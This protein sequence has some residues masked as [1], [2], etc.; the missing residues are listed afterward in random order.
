MTAVV[1]VKN[2]SVEDVY[3]VDSKLISKYTKL[4]MGKYPD[5]EDWI[6]PD[7]KA[8]SFDIDG[9]VG[10]ANGIRQI[11]VDEI[12]TYA[13]DVDYQSIDTNDNS[14]LVDLVCKNLNLI[15]IDQEIAADFKGKISL[16]VENKTT[17]IMTIYSRS[18]TV[19]P[20]GSKSGGSIASSTSTTSSTSIASSTSTAAGGSSS[21][22]GVDV[23]LI[24]HRTIPI[25]NL[26]P[27]RYLKISGIRIEQGYGKDD[28]GKFTLLN[29]VRYKINVDEKKRAM[30]I[31]YDPNSFSLRLETA[32][33]ITVDTLIDRIYAAGVG[34]LDRLAELLTD[35]KN[36]TEWHTEGLDVAFIDGVYVFSIYQEHYMLVNLL[37]QKCYLLNPDIPYCTKNKKMEK[38]AAVIYLKYDDPRR[39]L[40]DAIE[41]C[42]VD[43]DTFK[44]AF[45]NV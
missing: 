31:A 36:E 20:T 42:K 34:K 12:L 26:K 8:V 39:L 9:Y 3:S 7:R 33:N 1:K 38:D 13:M 17:S 35:Y 5:I 32:G 21:S 23:K 27:G 28:A 2:V 37:A 44:T 41:S 11:A 45:V 10:F 14:I 18:I 16:L 29:N 22:T 4:A 24:T 43:F 40:M 6:P 15:P 25:C 19:Y 30:S